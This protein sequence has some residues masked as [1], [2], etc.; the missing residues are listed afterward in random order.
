MPANP[1]LDEDDLDSLIAY[2]KAMK[3]RKDD[4]QPAPEH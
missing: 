3:A 1:H 2:L 4:P